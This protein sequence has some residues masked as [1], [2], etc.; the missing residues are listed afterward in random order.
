MQSSLISLIIIDELVLRIER[1]AVIDNW[2][3]FNW[4]IELIIGMVISIRK[5]AV[6][7][8]TL[9]FE[10]DPSSFCSM[11][12]VA[13]PDVKRQIIPAESLNSDS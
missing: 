2:I 9:I 5:F 13:L 10:I 6:E 1:E 3:L 7:G 12:S 11:K 4:Q 8:W